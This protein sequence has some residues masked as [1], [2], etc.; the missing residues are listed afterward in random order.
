MSTTIKT[1]RLLLRP[2]VDS[3]INYIF[4][5]LSD[6]KVVQHYAVRFDNLEA[7]KEQMEWYSD[8]RQLWWAICSLENKTFYG[9]GGL[10]D[11]SKEELKAEIGLWL[12]PKYWGKGIMKE[13]LPL[14][15]DYGLN[16][17][18]L[19]KIEGFVES[20]NINCKNAMSKLDYHLEETIEDFEIKN[21]QSISIGVYVK[22]R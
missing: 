13:A 11:I 7:T 6:P 10:N 4:A 2:I 12:L 19:N 15:T 9:A 16:K 18:G 5:G 3:D 1:D 8:D 14:I 17:L 20:N 22:C 21:G